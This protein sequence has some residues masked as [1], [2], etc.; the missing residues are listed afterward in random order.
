[1]RPMSF[2][3]GLVSINT[4]RRWTR[5]KHQQ[6]RTNSELLYVIILGVTV[7]EACSAGW[8]ARV[9]VYVCVFEADAEIWCGRPELRACALDL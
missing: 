3:L 9:R 6:D 8:C 7:A 5:H 2:V 4:V 1:M